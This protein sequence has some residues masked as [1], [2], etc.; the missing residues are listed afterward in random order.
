VEEKLIR[1]GPTVDPTDP[2]VSED[3]PDDDNM[4]DS[5]DGEFIQGKKKPPKPVKEMPPSH[6]IKF[7][8]RYLVLQNFRLH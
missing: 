4:E 8:L 5:P 6:F 2:E 7:D 3:E 1:L